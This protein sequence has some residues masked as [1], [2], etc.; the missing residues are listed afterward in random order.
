MK[1]LIIFS[2]FSFTLFLVSCNDNEELSTEPHAQNNEVAYGDKPESLEKGGYAEFEITLENLT[3]ATDAGASQPFSPPVITTHTFGYHIF[4]IFDY[5]S[6]E[7]WQLAED[8]VNAPL[9]NKLNNSSQAYSVVEGNSGPIFPGDSQTFTIKTKLPF[10]KLSLASM[11]VNTNDGFTGVDGMFLPYRGT[12]VRYL[13]AYDAGSEKNTELKS[14]IPGPCCGSHLM[15][16]PT[17]ER[18]KIHRG[19]KGVGDLDPA[20]YGWSKHVVA[21]LTITRLK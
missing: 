16:V 6:S 18:I 3:P 21:K 11:L 7:F 5:A 13:V 15:R 1:K 20:V 2:L 10:V 8:A 19:I 4:R 17:H 9:I 12:K 14:N